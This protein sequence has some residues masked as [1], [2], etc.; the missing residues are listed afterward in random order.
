VRHRIGTAAVLVDVGG[1]ERGA[2]HEE[3]GGQSLHG[4]EYMRSR[5][6]S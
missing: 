3:Q 1:G 4:L 2:G 5:D 6:E